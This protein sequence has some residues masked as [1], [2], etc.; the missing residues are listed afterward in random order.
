MDPVLPDQS[1]HFMRINPQND[2]LQR[3]EEVRQRA[4]QLY[5]ARGRQ[6]GLAID[7]WLA[8][9]AQIAKSPSRHPK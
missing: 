4:Y 6:G 8:A 3:M 9:E 7:D 5:E 1:G 2:E